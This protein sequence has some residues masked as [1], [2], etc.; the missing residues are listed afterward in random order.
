METEAPAV[1]E[2]TNA[3]SF[4]AEEGVVVRSNTVAPPPDDEVTHL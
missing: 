2:V 1:V 4:I 3:R